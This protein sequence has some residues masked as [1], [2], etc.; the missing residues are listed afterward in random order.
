MLYAAGLPED[1]NAS[2]YGA[3]AAGEGANTG[4]PGFFY[5]GHNQYG[6]PVG[7]GL[8][9]MHASGFGAAPYR[10]GVSSGGHMNNPR[11]GI[12]DIENIELQYPLVYLSRNHLIDS[13]G[14]GKYRGGLGLQ[15]I[16][17][18]YGTTNLTVNYSPYHGIPGGW[19]LFGGYPMG[20]GGSKFVV[21][22]RDLQ[23]KL[24]R[25]R[26]P[27]AFAE[28]AD[29]GSLVAPKL[30]ALQRL[31]IPEFFLIADPVGVGSGYGDPLDRP[32][33]LVLRDVVEGA[34]SRARAANVYGIVVAG[35]PPTIDAGASERRRKQIRDRRL[36]EAHAVHGGNSEFGRPDGASKTLCRMHE[37]VEI[38]RL[39]DG[40]LV[41]RCCKC[42]YVYGPAKE[43]YKLGA[44]RRIVD[45]GSTAEERLPDGA[46]YLAKLYE[47]F[48][49]GCGTQVD[50]ETH[51][52]DLE[53]EA[54]PFWDIRIEA[55]SDE[56]LWCPGRRGICAPRQVTMA[57][58]G[59]TVE[60]SG[61]ASSRRNGRMFGRN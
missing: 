33:E 53:A 56:V 57:T 29:W 60:A 42:D 16:I 4:G 46:A 2:W 12:S 31:Q 18:V 19:G 49:P 10:D 3:G 34:V 27:V 1:V 21:E 41:S 11:I 17:M 26:Y 61:M 47:Y 51:C 50:V 9:D 48:C 22:P 7:Q 58:A 23:E 54:T 15:R 24:S 45:L 14:Y 13:G 44:L 39:S 32:A 8:Y 20:I 43:N 40:R 35:E 59:T 36:A 30:P 52:P 25:S 28:V 5:G 6:L 37:Y 55:P 38:A